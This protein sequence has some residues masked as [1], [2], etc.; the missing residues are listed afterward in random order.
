MDAIGEYINWSHE[1]SRRTIEEA[2]ANDTLLTQDEV[3]ALPVDAVVAIHWSGGNGPWLYRIAA[4]R[5]GHVYLDR[6]IYADPIDF[7]GKERW[8]TKVARYEPSDD[9]ALDRVRAHWDRLQP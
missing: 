7:V 9:A 3:N 1:E 8:H 6:S 2:K 4:E 5:Y